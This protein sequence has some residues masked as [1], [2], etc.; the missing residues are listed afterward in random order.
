[1]A[2]AGIRELPLY[3]EDRP[4]TTPS[5][6]RILQI[7]SPLARTVILRHD[8]VLTVIEPA[9]SPLQGKLLALLGIP[10]SAYRAEPPPSRNP[11]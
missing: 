6:A 5:A 10:A 4:C 2:Q 3:H 9:L 8:Q 7:L 1:M 11:A